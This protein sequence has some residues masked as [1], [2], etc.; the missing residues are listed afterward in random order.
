MEYFECLFALLLRT[1]KNKL[2]MYTH[3]MS[4]NKESVNLAADGMGWPEFKR[5][6]SCTYVF[7]WNTKYACLHHA[8]P[9]QCNVKHGPHHFDLSPLIKES[10]SMYLRFLMYYNAFL[11]Y[12]RNRRTMNLTIDQTVFQINRILFSLY[13]YI[14]CKSEFKGNGCLN[15]AILNTYTF[16]FR[17]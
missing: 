6:D 8:L 13:F 2:H 17:W 10:Q 16:M 7:D 1:W 5:E 3:A 4:I 14:I 15:A 9:T 11:V 12:F